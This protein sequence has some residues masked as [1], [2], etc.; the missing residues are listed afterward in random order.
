MLM[1]AAGLARSYVKTLETALRTS[2]ETALDTVVSAIS[3]T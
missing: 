3:M 2:A 1:Q